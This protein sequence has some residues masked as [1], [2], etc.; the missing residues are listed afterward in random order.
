VV[1]CTVGSR[2]YL[3]SQEPEVRRDGGGDEDGGNKCEVGCAGHITR[4]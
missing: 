1:G 3:A 4:V 2:G